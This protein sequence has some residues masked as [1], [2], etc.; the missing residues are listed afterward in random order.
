MQAFV[1]LVLMVLGFY[2]LVLFARIVLDFMR[3]VSPDWSPSGV[4]LVVANA[5]FGLTDPPLRFLRRFVPPIGLGAFV[6]DTAFLVLIFGIGVLERLVRA[7]A[8]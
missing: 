2:E 6:L 7:L 8:F 5:V 4:F 3:M 1:S